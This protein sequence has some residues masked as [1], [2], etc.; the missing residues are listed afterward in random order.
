[1]SLQSQLSTLEASALV[2]LAATEPEIEYLFRHAL[3]QEAAYG[4]IL[5][6]DRRTL[7][8][9]VAETLERLYPDQLDELAVLLAY[10]FEAA[11]AWPRALQWLTRAADRA[12]A[13]FALVEARE[14]YQR[15][16]NSL[17][18][19]SPAPQREFDLRLHL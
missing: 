13:E 19:L 8:V 16:L 2:R 12:N 5:K 18:H 6:A 10:H 7:H 1:M 14:L 3:V 11:Q 15:A 9:A 17:A 4:S